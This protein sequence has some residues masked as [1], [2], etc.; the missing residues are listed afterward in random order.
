MKHAYFLVWGKRHAT[1]TTVTENVDHF[2]IV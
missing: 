1:V 2:V